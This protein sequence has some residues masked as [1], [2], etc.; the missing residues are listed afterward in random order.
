MK[1]LLSL[2]G[3]LQPHRKLPVDARVRVPAR[4]S[5]PSKP[6]PRQPATSGPAPG[7]F[8]STL[9][10]REEMLAWQKTPWELA[11]ELR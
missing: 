10:L 1:F 8:G 9:L 11:V 7:Q 2:L 5:A 3:V 6:A 4:D